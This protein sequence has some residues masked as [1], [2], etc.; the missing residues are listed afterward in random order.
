[1]ADLESTAVLGLITLVAM[2]SPP[3][4]SGWDSG[5]GG[6][7]LEGAGG[8]AG[9]CAHAVEVPLGAAAPGEE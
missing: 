4:W 8:S 1:M 6:S 3:I 2:A 5:G 7:T 9:G